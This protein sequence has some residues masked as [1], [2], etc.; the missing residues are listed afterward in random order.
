MSLLDRQ[1]AWLLLHCECESLKDQEPSGLCVACGIAVSLEGASP[2]WVQTISGE[3]VMA[4]VC[5]AACVERRRLAQQQTWRR[6]AELVEYYTGRELDVL[7]AEYAK[8][9]GQ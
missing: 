8:E 9:H 1:R 4:S 7:E 2:Q 6:A 5:G 3:W